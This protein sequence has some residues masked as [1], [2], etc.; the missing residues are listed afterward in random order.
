MTAHEFLRTQGCGV[1]T[2]GVVYV[3]GSFALPK[4]PRG[5]LE[6]QGSIILV[7][8]FASQGLS[9]LSTLPASALGIQAW[10]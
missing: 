3:R 6:T 2:E 1:R 5:C 7:Y 8:L 10:H 4:P 9:L